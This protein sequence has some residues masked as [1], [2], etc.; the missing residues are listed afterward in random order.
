MVILHVSEHHTTLRV[1]QE[2][3]P[4]Q[5]GS[6]SP[7]WVHPAPSQGQNTAAQQQQPNT[8]PRVPLHLSVLPLI[9]NLCTP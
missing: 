2:L 5:H 9:I 6:S 7:L 8:R 3:T 1:D 4:D